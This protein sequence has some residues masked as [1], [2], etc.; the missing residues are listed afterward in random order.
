MPFLLTSLYFVSRYSTQLCSC[1]N[2]FNFTHL[3]SLSGLLYFLFDISV[4]EY[5][6]IRKGKEKITGNKNLSMLCK[7]QRATLPSRYPVPYNSLVLSDWSWEIRATMSSILLQVA[8]FNLDYKASISRPLAP[9]KYHEIYKEKGLQSRSMTSRLFIKVKV[10]AE[11]H[12]RAL[13]KGSQLVLT[14]ARATLNKR[15]NRD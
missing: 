4:P 10:Y 7:E 6:E 2:H 5:L 12:Q 9:N 11:S 14:L 15:N 8:S 1:C 13:R 3:I